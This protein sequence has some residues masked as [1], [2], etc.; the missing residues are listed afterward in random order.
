[1][2]VGTASSAWAADPMC[3]A[4]QEFAHAQ[5]DKTAH[6]VEL[7]TDWGGL[8][9]A[10]GVIASKQCLDGDY[11]PGKNLCKYLIGDNTS[12]EFA[13]DNLG[14]ALRCLSSKPFTGPADVYSELL[15]VRY[16]S[17]GPPVLP[18]NIAVTLELNLDRKDGPPS[19]K[20]TSERIGD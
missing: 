16:S 18:E 14:R 3:A 4:I 10:P 5:K 15:H 1:M 2:F 6:T 20:I 9:S 11:L 19:L 17:V 13:Q 12:T 8:Y 7:L